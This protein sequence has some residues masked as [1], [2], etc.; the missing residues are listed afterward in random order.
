VPSRTIRDTLRVTQKKHR[1]E[2]VHFDEYK[3]T[4]KI[5]LQQF[6]MVVDGIQANRIL[7]ERCISYLSG[8]SNSLYWPSGCDLWMAQLQR[9]H[10]LKMTAETLYN[11]FKDAQSESSGAVVHNV[12]YEHRDPL[13]H[14]RLS[15]I[16]T[17]V[18]VIV[19]KYPRTATLLGMYHDSRSPL[20]RAFAHDIDCENSEVVEK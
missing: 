4:Q 5:D 15:A 20:V 12:Y 2:V 18:E 8:A 6:K 1:A 3:C 11:H 17:H 16:G 19:G 10:E 9:C 7:R 13:Y 14:G